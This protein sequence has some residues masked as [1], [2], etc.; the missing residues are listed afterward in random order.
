MKRHKIYTVMMLVCT[1]VLTL[2]TM[3]SEKN[4]IS[5]IA[6][7][8][9]NYKTLKFKIGES[10]FNPKL[11]TFDLAFTGAYKA[12]Y[13]TLNY[14][15]SLKDAYV[16]D[17]NP[18]LQDDTIMTVSREDTGL[19]LGYGITESFSL[20]GGYMKGSTKLFRIANQDAI[21]TEPSR[22]HT[23]AEIN[24]E[25]PFAGLSYSIGFSNDK[26]LALSLAYT[27]MS[28]ELTADEGASARKY[29]GDTTG[30]SYG[31]S[32]SGPLVES[33]GYR[34]GIKTNRYEFKQDLVPGE[35]D[36]SH[37]QIYTMFFVGI[38]NYF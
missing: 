28:G 33:M 36:L 29:V 20:F 35:D 24:M 27:N 37:D 34:I 2:E 23:A 21:G 17:Y 4:D 7:G 11:T 16:Y 12:F 14:D 1:M 9:I 18:A 30:F 26:V 31:I 25:G 32:L 15:Q 8:T 19:T 5:V 22:F 10:E 3:A 13:A 38:S 6:S